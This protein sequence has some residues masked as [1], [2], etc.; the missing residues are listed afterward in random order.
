MNKAEIGLL[1]VRTRHQA[2]LT[3]KE[4]ARR[5]GT[6]Q[7]VIARAENGVVLPTLSFLQRFASATGKPVNIRLDPEKREMTRQ[8]RR[9]RVRRATNNFVFNP[10]DRDPSPTE[11]KSLLADGLTRERFEGQ[12]TARTGSH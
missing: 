4:V 5:M 10:W 9:R 11:A 3:Q 7:S 1:L 12:R 8:S 6:A 2:G